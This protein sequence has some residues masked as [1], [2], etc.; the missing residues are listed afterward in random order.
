MALNSG[1]RL[2]TY[3][4]TSLIGAGGMGEVYQAHDSKL[5][6]D[7]A[8]KVLPERFARDSER[9]AR[10][11][12]EAKMLAAL[13]H[14]NIA[15]IYGLEQSGD[16]HYLVM[17]LVPG[18][19]LRERVAGERPIPVEEAL[20][21]AKQIAEALEAAHNSEKVINHRDL[22]PANVKV[23]PEGRV[24][25][26]DFGLAKA[27]AVEPSAEDIANSPTLSAAPT[28]QGVIMGTAAY[29]SPEQARGKHVNKATD[30]FA[31][32]AVL[33][34]LLTGKQAFQGEDVTDILASVVKAEPDWK[35]LPGATPP[36]IRTLLRRCLRKDRRQRLQDATGLRI[37][38]EDVLS[39]AAAA[40]PVPVGRSKQRERLAW[41]AAVV[42]LVSTVALSLWVVS[43]RR[44]LVE[45]QAIQFSVGP[46]ENT[47]FSGQTT[48][49]SISPDGNKLAFV[50]VSVES[51][52]RQL[53]IRALDSEAAQPLPGTENPEQPFWS[54][55]S[56]FLA[57]YADGKLKKIAV[58]GGP[59]QT[60]TEAPL[61][62]NGT[63]S[64]EGVVL[65]GSA[66][67]E[68]TVTVGMTIRRVSATG[69]A[70]TPV[71]TLDASRGENS[72]YWPHF[73][74]GGNHFLYLARSRNPENSA[75]YAASL[76]SQER[77]LLLTADSN[78]VY[79]S[80]GYLLF[81][82]EGTLMAQAFD[83]ER[84]EL[85]GEEVP[86]AEDV[87]FNTDGRAAFAASENGVLAYRTG[88][89]TASTQLVWFDRTGK[90]IRV[91]G[92][93]SAYGDLELSSDGTRASVSILDPTRGRRDIWVYD[94]ARGLK[95]RFTFDPAHEQN[96]IWSPDGNR[97]IFTSNLKGH[98]DLYQKASD[99]S[100][101]E[102]VLLEDNL[103][104]FPT[105]WSPDGRFILFTSI[106]AQTRNDLF[107]LPL[108]GDRKPI[109]FLQTQFPEYFG[110]FSPDGR[111]VTYVS[112]ESGTPEVYVAPFP[113]PGGKWLVSTAG[114]EHPRWRPDGTEVFYRAL[115]NRLMAA[116]VNGKGSSFEVGAVT[117]LFQTTAFLGGRWPYDV[118]A[119]GQ[120]FLINT[121]PE[122]VGSAPIT[123]VVNW[124]AGLRK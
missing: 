97:I 33:Y 59:A 92:D 47:R 35:Q 69:G 71:S 122:Q 18:P 58:S 100:G 11:Q 78:V 34:E 53:W 61:G 16:T 23:T 46:P 119:D 76:D 75:I 70:A 80:P 38:I 57:F 118:S 112:N 86:I 9:L 21:I 10:F 51:G 113:G 30:I 3:T 24:K 63:W 67:A 52:K 4:I 95:T 15:A 110:Q 12:R 85:T 31:F 5:D 123:V 14:P 103:D 2:G 91:L 25:V 6:R 99:G 74:P 65:F 117:P 96:S 116:A 1:T 72:H 106:G 7:V 55:D 20:V 109:S 73:L 64:R 120:R 81:N 93:Q 89:G 22:K 28:M 124:M 44:P 121:L 37:E 39:G 105:S 79:V 8:I 108:S 82:R 42:L 88:A 104:K 107:V 102:E 43:L 49:L 29:M 62:A 84:L 45:Q 54:A 13:N 32:G 19:T 41:L 101:R 83:A 77:K 87:Q 48:L 36:A 50:G 94:V 27:F 40:E 111:W 17:E 60:L 66:G 56:R 115:D 114:G 26:L 68:G 90:Q 98:Y